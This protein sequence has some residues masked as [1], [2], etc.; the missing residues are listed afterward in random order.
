MIS[1]AKR[2]VYPLKQS[3]FI[4]HKVKNKWDE[5]WLPVDDQ[6]HSTGMQDMLGTWVIDEDQR[7]RVGTFSLAVAMRRVDSHHQK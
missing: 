2:T 3:W 7:I 6:P 1:K 4:P 5:R